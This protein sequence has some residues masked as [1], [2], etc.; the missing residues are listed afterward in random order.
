MI[1]VTDIS[2]QSKDR[3]SSDTIFTC[4]FFCPFS[5]QLHS[6]S[7]PS[8]F[9]LMFI[10]LCSLFLCFVHEQTTRTQFNWLLPVTKTQSTWLP[11]SQNSPVPLQPPDLVLEPFWPLSPALTVQSSGLSGHSTSRSASTAQRP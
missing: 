4:I 7:L 1:C 2:N 8:P 5:T 11:T 6:L 9:P 3:L 10:F